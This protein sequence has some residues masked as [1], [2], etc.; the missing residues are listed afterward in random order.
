MLELNLILS[1]EAE[2]D[3]SKLDK[4]LQIRI[5]KKLDWFEK[6]FN[7]TNPLPLMGEWQGFFKIRVSDWRV[8]YEINRRENKIIVRL[9]DRRDRIYKRKLR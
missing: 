4:S 3:L 1:D 5:I 2:K 6:N 8:I 9:I 7:V